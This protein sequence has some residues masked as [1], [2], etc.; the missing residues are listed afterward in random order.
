MKTIGT[1]LLLLGAIGTIIFGIQ[2]IQDSDSF[3]F[4]GMDIAVSTAN[5]T[6]VIIS[7]VI[8]IVGL[9]MTMRGKKV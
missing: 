1:I 8:L 3:S 7:A 6:P 2:A 5:W 4:L 9:V